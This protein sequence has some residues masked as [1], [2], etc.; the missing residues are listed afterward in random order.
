M[1]KVRVLFLFIFDQ[2][3]QYS[4]LRGGGRGLSFVPFMS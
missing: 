4:S 3:I 2:S 1:G